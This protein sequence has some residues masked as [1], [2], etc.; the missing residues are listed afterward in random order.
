VIGTTTV[1]V[2]LAL[3]PGERVTFSLSRE[4]SKRN[5]EVEIRMRPLNPPT[6]VNV[7]PVEPLA[8]A[9]SV[10]VPELNEI[11]KSEA[12]GPNGDTPIGDET[13]GASMAASII[14]TRHTRRAIRIATNFLDSKCDTKTINSL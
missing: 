8:P 4:A 11:V 3:P 13:N 6:L 5:V 7:T 1:R 14:G 12:P 2:A 10:M 9:A